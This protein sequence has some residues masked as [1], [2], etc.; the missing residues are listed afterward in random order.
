ME[1][2]L[3]QR[4]IFSSFPVLKLIGLPPTP[5]S[6]TL[7]APSLPGGRMT[8]PL[9][10]GTRESAGPVDK[11]KSESHWAEMSE[12]NKTLDSWRILRL[13]EA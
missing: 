8:L 6:A 12:N 13:E 2:A 4:D 1:K 9:S 3:V 10:L 11:M 7:L 5:H